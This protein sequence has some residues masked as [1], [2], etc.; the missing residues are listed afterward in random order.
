MS[1]YLHLRI[2]RLFRYDI[3]AR[4]V[5]LS[6]LVVI[7]LT[8]CSTDPYF[9]RLPGKKTGIHF[10][11][12]IQGNDSNHVGNHSF[13]YNGAGVGII[14]V[15]NDGLPDIY[16]AGNQVSSRL[17]LNE[18]NMRFKDITEQSG[19]ATQRWVTGIS[20][21]DINSDGFSDLYCS[22]LGGPLVS[23]T[24]IHNLLFINNGDNTFSE[25]AADYGIGDNG[26]TTH[27]AFLD[28]DNDGDLDLYLINSSSEDFGRD[29]FIRPEHEGVH[30]RLS[31][32]FYKN[33]GDGTF[34]NISVEAGIYPEGYGLG[35]AVDDFND[36]QNP[37]IY[38]SNDIFTN[39]KL[40]INT[41]NG[42]FENK[43]AEYIVF[44]SFSGM[45]VDIGDFN[46]D[47]WPDIYQVDMLPETE[48]ERNKTLINQG[49]SQD[50]L[51]RKLGYSPQRIQ[52]TL[53]LHRGMVGEDILFE[54][55]AKQSN[56]EATGWSWAP[57]FADL[58]NNGRQDLIVTNGYPK[59]LISQEYARALNDIGPFGT[60]NTK[61]QKKTNIL[62]E[63]ESIQ[64]SNKFF[65]NNGD[66]TF[67]DVSKEWGFHKSGFSYGAAT[68]DLDNDG[69]LD[70]VVNN[71][72]ESAA[73]Y[74]NKL[75]SNSG[76]NQVPSFISVELNGIGM[77]PDA[78]GSKIIVVT[79]HERQRKYL[80]PYR[81]YA[82]SVDIRAH[83]GL[84]NASVVDSIIVVWPDGT[85]QITTQLSVNQ[86]MTINKQFNQQDVK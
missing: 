76:G 60:E 24:T 20:V 16:F 13:M 82:S 49:S 48:Q 50:D 18:G 78:I 40:W 6:S 34:T 46:N 11:N 9:E 33:N 69:D 81:G 10:I 74:E 32:V 23:D 43:I 22:V 71:L 55:R 65:R 37:D 57:L 21:V 14:D 4:M 19:T 45:G 8:G 73:V 2:Q 1:L 27:A 25:R 42:Y 7:G 51:L 70:L 62:K 3:F 36:D 63:L 30:P 75:R 41:G 84:G 53:Q 85:R 79:E 56:V 35:I 39:D 52:N 86:Q 68:S 59:N 61:Q 17:Y 26:S 29:R 31:D 72:N 80:S 5:I 15:N 66:S 83:F 44:T 54:E 77:N 38:V 67:S 64:I 58:N 28:Y 47:G 12:K